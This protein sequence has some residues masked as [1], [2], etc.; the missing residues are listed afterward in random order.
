MV[1]GTVQED[2]HHIG[3]ER[4]RIEEVLK[5]VRQEDSPAARLNPV[6]GLMMFRVARVYANLIG[7]LEAPLVDVFFI[8]CAPVGLSHA[9]P[10]VHLM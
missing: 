3:R 8:A 10:P 7:Q 1:V 9:W 5:H 2:Y 4:C 6:P